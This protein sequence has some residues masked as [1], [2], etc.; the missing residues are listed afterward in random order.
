M[1]RRR[2][3]ELRQ[4]CLNL[5]GE[6]SLIFA[7]GYDA[8]LIGIGWR[9]GIPITIYDRQGVIDILCRRNGMTPEDAEEF[10][11]Y[12]VAGSWLGEATPMFVDL[13]QVG[14]SRGPSLA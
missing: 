12:N 10:F 6:E 8:A 3:S 11:D 9:D 1:P 4:R 5:V 7:E 14:R 2:R 13:V